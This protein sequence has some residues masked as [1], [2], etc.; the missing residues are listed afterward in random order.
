MKRLVEECKAIEEGTRSLDQIARVEFECLFDKKAL[1]KEQKGFV[2][3]VRE[4][5]RLAEEIA[6]LEKG[7]LSARRKKQIQELRSRVIKRIQEMSLQHHI[8]NDFFE[9]VQI[10]CPNGADFARRVA[11]IGKGENRKRRGD[12]RVKETVA[13]GGRFPGQENLS[14]DQADSSING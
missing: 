3:R 8:I 13:G 7:R 9:R 11:S 1:A 14:A 5:G 12:K 2:R 10:H 6:D 4:V